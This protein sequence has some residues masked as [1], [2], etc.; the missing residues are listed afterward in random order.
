VE[1]FQLRI[2][3]RGWGGKGE[4][5]FTGGKKRAHVKRKKGEELNEEER[6]IV[7]GKA[8]GR[9]ERR[10]KGRGRRGGHTKK[11]WTGGKSDQRE[12]KS[13]VKGQV[14]KPGG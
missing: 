3:R 8:K 7:K 9:S 4:R 2:R 11:E 13:E 6:E 1:T 5:A 12:R 14:R 10:R